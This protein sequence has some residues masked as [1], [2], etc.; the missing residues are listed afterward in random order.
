MVK[1]LDLSLAGYP[2][3]TW[4]PPWTLSCVCLCCNVMLYALEPFL[5][6]SNKVHILSAEPS[7]RII[8]KEETLTICLIKQRRYPLVS[9]QFVEELNQRVSTFVT[10]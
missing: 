2:V 3:L 10:N 8:V 5:T 6:T 1:D 4:R 7:I 9:F